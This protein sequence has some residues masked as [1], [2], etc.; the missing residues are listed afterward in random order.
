MTSLPFASSTGTLRERLI[1]DVT[2]RGFTNK[3]RK[4]YLRIVTTFPTFVGRSPCTATAEDIRRL[5]IEQPERGMN[6]P[7]MNSTLAVLRFSLLN[8]T[9]DRPNLSR[10]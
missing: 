6:S 3:T 4:D 10:S 1:P 5:Q 7:A 9:V 2:L 8:H